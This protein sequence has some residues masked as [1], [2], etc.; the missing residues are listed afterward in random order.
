[1]DDAF[2]TLSTVPCPSSSIAPP[3][4]ASYLHLPWSALRR[5]RGSSWL[6][7]QLLGLHLAAPF[8]FYLSISLF[9]LSLSNTR[10]HTHTHTPRKAAICFAKRHS[11]V[12]TETTCFPSPH[13]LLFHY[14]DMQYIYKRLGTLPHATHATKQTHHSTNYSMI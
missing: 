9:F 13:G 5:R 2:S 6:W 1:V 8:F 10:T 14:A 12:I 11:L 7:Y 3:P 4:D